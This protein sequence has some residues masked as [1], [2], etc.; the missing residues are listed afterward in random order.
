MTTT[1]EQL[2]VNGIDYEF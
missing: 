1:T 2:S